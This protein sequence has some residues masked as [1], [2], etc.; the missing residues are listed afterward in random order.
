MAIRQIQDDA[1]AIGMPSRTE[2]EGWY[3]SRPATAHWIGKGNVSYL[4]DNAT[5]RVLQVVSRPD[6]SLSS[7]VSAIFREGV[8][9]VVSALLPVAGEFIA[10]ELGVSKFVGTTIAQISFSLAQGV[11]LDKALASA[12]TNFVTTGVLNSTQAQN[13]L[14]QLSTD[15]AIIKIINNAAKATLNTALSGGSLQQILT[16]TLYT[17][18]GSVTGQK[19]DSQIIGQAVATALLTGGDP[20]A[21]TKSIA[22]SLA[23]Q[24]NATASPTPTTEPTTEPTTD[25][26]QTPT[27]EPIATTDQATSLF[28]QIYGRAPSPE[29]LESVKTM[30]AEQITKTLTDARDAWLAATPTAAPTTEPTTSPTDTPQ[31]IEE[32]K[33]RLEQDAA[34]SA[35]AM[36]A[37]SSQRV[38][39]IDA[40]AERYSAQE[41]PGVFKAFENWLNVN[42][43]SQFTEANPVD[44]TS[45]RSYM[46]AQGISDANIDY[47]LEAAKTSTDAYVTSQAGKAEAERAAREAT[48]RSREVL[49]RVPASAIPF[50]D[51]SG[52]TVFFDTVSQKYFDSNGNETGRTLADEATKKAVELIAKIQE[53]SRTPTIQDGENIAVLIRQ[54]A[55]TERINPDGTIKPVDPAEI[56]KLFLTSANSNIIS[57]MRLEGINDI[58]AI[59]GSEVIRNMGTEVFKSELANELLRYPNDPNLNEAFQKTAGYDWTETPQ[60]RAYTN[61]TN[62]LPGHEGRVIEVKDSQGHVYY[63]VPI[64]SN[65]SPSSQ[66][67]AYMAIYDPTTG[68]T[69]YDANY[70]YNTINNFSNLS[71]TVPVYDESGNFTGYK[72]QNYV[73]VNV[74]PTTGRALVIDEKGN[75]KI[76]TFTGT[77]PVAG[78]SVSVNNQTNTVVTPTAPVVSPTTSTT[79]TPTSFPT[80][81]PSPTPTID[82][83]TLPTTVPSPTPSTVP[84]STTTPTTAPTTLPTTAPTVSPTISPTTTP[85]TSPSPITVPTSSTSP[86][87]II[88]VSPSVQPSV[89]PTTSPTLI[90]TV[91]TT[92]TTTLSPTPT[93]VP[94]PS[95]SPSP[96]TTVPTP[97]SIF[98]AGPTAPSST[99]TT[100]PTTTVVPTEIP[101]VE[102]TTSPTPT[103]TPS[104]TPTIGIQVPP[105]ASVKKRLP[106]ITGYGRSPLEQAL[107]AYRPP[108][109]VEGES[110]LDR[111]NVWNE[112]SL[113]LKDALGI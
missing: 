52:K 6:F 62:I 77:P 42:P 24:S 78:A 72:P 26:T 90:P 70:N 44:E 28:Q 110:G 30:T 112:A 67:G 21:I 96:I 39:F 84:T 1:A 92:P 12:A 68:Q 57:A 80:E 19:I 94:T 55:G 3:V 100:S 95:A 38:R 4:V 32:V 14:N 75:S 86:T 85:S 102:P 76:V 10:T 106:T 49:S 41:L 71:S 37:S 69:K 59:L 74:D 103:K 25:P 18:I 105:K 16:N 88:S 15:P 91:T 48:A 54:E 73:V 29:E 107:S 35:A 60:G 47:I 93:R 11:P 40:L 13:F 113:R 50:T 27:Q 34:T 53:S 43:N 20:L 8:P 99:Q 31:T 63:A 83:T 9:M 61:L 65:L 23:N 101:T 87:P 46:R 2:S 97:T 109:E 51:S 7:A 111:Q 45:F 17:V 5:G 98:T 22:M 81:I 79:E 82:I 108:G 56:L 66:G 58:G 104:P 36:L 64:T 89:Q 33:R